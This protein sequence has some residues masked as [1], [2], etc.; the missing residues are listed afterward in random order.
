MKHWTLDDIPWE[1][2]D[3]SR[4]DPEVVKVVKAAAMV[5]A[6]GGDYATYLCNVFHD[7]PEFQQV[8]NEWAM[9]EVQHG[10]ALARWAKL[11]DPT[12]DFDAAFKR[13]TDGF[14]IE[15]WRTH[16][17]RGSRSGELVSRCIV[18]TGTSSYYSALKDA[19]EEPVLK[20]ICRNIAAD[21]FRHYKLFYTYLL[22]YLEA[23]KIGSFGRFLAAAS[24]I[25][26]SEDDELA[27]AYYA[28][29]HPV[30]ALY[31]RKRFIRAYL[32]RAYRFY[33]PPHIERGI[34]MI[35]KAIGLTPNGWLNAILTR[36][37]SWMLRV[38]V[39]RLARVAT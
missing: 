16:S 8:A 15:T 19:V 26:E 17:L 35:L 36:W 32:S 23:E 7:D 24:R 2:F 28:A 13:F 5:E 22:R 20:E 37:I 9:E 1:R 29:N 11:V 30:D 21:E 39:H 31:E 4:V 12:F 27:Y 38:R 34:G 14:K 3:R 18:E 6:N 25:R 33:R 10:M